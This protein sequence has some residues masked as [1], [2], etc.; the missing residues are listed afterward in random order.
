MIIPF[1]KPDVKCSFCGR[2]KDTVAKMVAGL[3]GKHICGHCIAECR[4][5]L[6]EECTTTSST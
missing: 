6:E 4:K 2:S 5:R 1:K 3:N